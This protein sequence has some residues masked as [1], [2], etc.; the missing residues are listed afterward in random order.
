MSKKTNLAVITQMDSPDD[1]NMKRIIIQ[2][3]EL[4]KLSR[5]SADED[6]QKVILELAEAVAKYDETTVMQRIED[7]EINDV[8]NNV[9]ST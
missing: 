1:Y 6:A 9:F 5:Y 8:W 4:L 2:A 7:K 3:G